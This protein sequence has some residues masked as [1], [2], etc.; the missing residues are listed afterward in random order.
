MTIVV[1]TAAKNTKPPN[2]PSA[3]MAPVKKSE[4]IG[5][6]MHNPREIY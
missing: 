6:K 5:I 4:C 1:M 3:I 2:T